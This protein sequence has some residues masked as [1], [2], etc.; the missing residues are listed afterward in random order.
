MCGSTDKLDVHHDEPANPSSS[1]TCIMWPSTRTHEHDE[2]ETQDP[3]TP[4]HRSVEDERADDRHAIPHTHTH[5]PNPT[6]PTPPGG[7]GSGRHSRR[8][9]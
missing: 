1:A 6:Q 8:F 9:V 2:H 5:T 7:E 4:L 3:P